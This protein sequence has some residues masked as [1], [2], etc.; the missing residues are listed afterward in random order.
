MNDGTGNSKN[1]KSM[2]LAHRTPP[3]MAEGVRAS[4]EVAVRAG[5]AHIL[6]ADRPE[7]EA[8]ALDAYLTSLRPV[9]SP[10]LVDGRLSPAAERGRQLFSSDRI[11]CQRC[12]PPPLYTDLRA[13]DVGTVRPNE[14][15]GRFDTPTLAE[16]WR[17][18]PYLHDGRYVTVRELLADGKHGLRPGP[19]G[20][21][22]S[23]EL[24][25]LVE[26]VLSL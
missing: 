11:G 22:S 26:F 4:A 14:R 3:S 18:A 7:D 9:P 23:G 16:V 10:R 25:D 15:K 19:S 13:H 17:T 2:L 20:E 6:F 8:A 21:L 5:L 1:T 24:D 12:H